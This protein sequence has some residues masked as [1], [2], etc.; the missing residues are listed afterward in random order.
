MSS[1]APHVLVTDVGEDSKKADAREEDSLKTLASVQEHAGQEAGK[2]LAADFASHAQELLKQSVADKQ[3][4]ASYERKSVALRGKA[5]D[6]VQHAKD[7]TRRAAAEK[8][9]EVGQKA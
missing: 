7:V 2:T 6:L 3:S 4:A 9:A 8:A 1:W 5:H